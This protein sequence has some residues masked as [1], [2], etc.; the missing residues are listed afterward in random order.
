MYWFYSR[1]EV[2]RRMMH[3][4]LEQHCQRIRE[5]ERC[6]AVGNAAIEAPVVTEF[7]SSV[8]H[9]ASGLPREDWTDAVD[10]TNRGIWRARGQCGS[11]FGGPR[12]NF[13]A[14]SLQGLFPQ[15]WELHQP[16]RC[17]CV[18][19][20]FAALLGLGVL[21][22]VFF[23][24][25]LASVWIA[26]RTRAAAVAEGNES[27]DL[28]RE[29]SWCVFFVASGT[30][31]SFTTR[32]CSTARCW[33]RSCCRCAAVVYIF[34]SVGREAQGIGL[35]GRPSRF[36]E[37][38]RT[39][40]A[41]FVWSRPARRSSPTSWSVFSAWI[42]IDAGRAADVEFAKLFSTEV[43][44]AYVDGVFRGLM[45]TRCRRRM[46]HVCVFIARTAVGADAVVRLASSE[47]TGCCGVST[48][49]V[50]VAVSLSAPSLFC[51]RHWCVAAG[52]SGS[53]P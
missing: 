52:G 36:S 27:G 35:C 44:C 47:G 1:D 43:V 5:M 30:V 34:A 46:F 53:T 31:V 49:A 48:V 45:R 19:T 50:E 23:A 28:A 9:G 3:H 12:Q 40:K 37:F 13:C 29:G 24:F 15:G 38:L 42:I 6:N 2:L 26:W 14:P 11:D 17:V 16:V 39:P 21:F 8:Y 10:G 25:L 7:K 41:V 4:S 22:V 18:L 32:R 51:L 20:F 33:L